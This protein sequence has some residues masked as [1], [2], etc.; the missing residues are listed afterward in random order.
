VLREVGHAAFEDKTLRPLLLDEPSVM[1]IESISVDQFEVRVV[2]RTLPGK[3]F[4]VGRTLRVRISAALRK[5]GITA[6]AMTV[7]TDAAGVEPSS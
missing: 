3:Q 5:A 7:Q 6:P 1:G 2:A 4:E